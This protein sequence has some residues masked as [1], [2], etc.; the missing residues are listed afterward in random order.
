MIWLIGNK[1]M[2][3]SE[4]ELL[5]KGRSYTASDKEI[6]ITNIDVLKNFVKD[7]NIEWIINCSSYTAV[8][9][10]EE[11][12]E[13][14]FAINSMGVF[15]LAEIAYRNGIKLI[16]I[17]TDYVFDGEI[18]TKY[19]ENSTP[20]PIN[21]YGDSKLEGEKNIRRI[22]TEF[23]IIRTAWL[24]GKNGNNFVN[25]MLRL[26]K[27]KDSINV[28]NDQ[29]GSPTYTKDLA[30]VIIDIID[31]NYEYGIYHYTN[32]GKITWYEFAKEICNLAN[33]D[34]II[35]PITTNEYPTKA[36][37]PKNSYL[38]KDKIKQYVRIKDWK[39]SLEN[40]IKEV[41]IKKGN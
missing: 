16:H 1:G 20:N 37:R 35:N 41:K 38:S 2:L 24:Y 10:A 31:T 9:K 14:A 25:T 27:E 32:E 15:N 5:L 11:E 17:S 33:A 3:G 12:I 26:F 23:Y 40:Y 29:F 30:G 22:L 21:V 18:E 13:Q 39:E 28:V 4:V 34:I 8:D 6:D 19:H 7:K 36:K